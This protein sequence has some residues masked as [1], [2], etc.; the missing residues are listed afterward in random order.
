MPCDARRYSDQ[1]MCGKCGLGW[2]MNDPDPPECGRHARAA[3]PAL[4]AAKV[5]GRAILAKLKEELQR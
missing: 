5:D 3:V 4:P 2:D 1:M